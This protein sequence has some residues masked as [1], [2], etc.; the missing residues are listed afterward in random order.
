MDVVPRL[1]SADTEGIQAHLIT[2]EAD[3]NVGLHAF[4][5]VGLV[6]KSLNEAR[7]RVNSALKHS[8][9]RPP[10]RENKKITINLAPADL[11]KSGSK[12]DLAIATAY[13]LA[14]R[15]INFFETSDKIFLGE[16]GLDGSVRPVFGVLSVALLAK[17]KKFKYIFVP[18]ENAEEAAAVKDIQVVPVGSLKNLI[19]HL[20]NRASIPIQE[21]TDFQPG[22]RGS[23]VDIDDIKGLRSA[24]RA[25]LV[26]AAGGHNLF[27]S[28]P[29]GGGKTMLA[30][31]L[32]S[33]LPP[34]S[35]E[36]SIEIT[37]I[38]SSVGLNKRE[39]F[40]TY[41][42]F[43]APHHS[44]SSAA[45]VGG[46][47]DPR[48]GEVS[49]AHRGVLFLDEA[50][51]FRRD[52]LESLRQPLEGGTINVARARG[53]VAFPA[54][55]QLVLAM[56]PCPCGYYGDRVITCKCSAHEIFRYQK[57]ISGPLLDRID[58]QLEVPRID[59][60]ELRAS[61]NEAVREG[62]F[63]RRQ[64]EE[65]RELQ[66]RRFEKNGLN[67]KT[68]AEIRSRDLDN[69]MKLQDDAEAFLKRILENSTITSRGY[70]RILRI[71]MT[72]ADLDKAGAVSSDHLAEAF[73][74][75]LKN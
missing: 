64:A 57:R 24:K 54:C 72:I 14:S 45:I 66:R 11:K 34:P 53:S 46:G 22:K 27:L 60:E 58:I 68:N 5:I 30:Q 65:A 29:P 49:L 31:A 74:Y 12:F 26:A 23:D 8:G 3:L 67:Y 40:I 19:D 63:F 25:L 37:Q 33:I 6:D 13:M 44:A 48:P 9:I 69:L 47:Q 21:S 56:N 62:E 70:Y 51:E 18:R 55:F 10:T 73:Q 2:V 15:Q 75:R 35:F 32:I 7:E 50:P 59:L 20:E 1:F 16:L 28:G 39:S 43:R 61:R 38:H 41:R 36:E 42:P 4:N 71:A 17:T 52:V